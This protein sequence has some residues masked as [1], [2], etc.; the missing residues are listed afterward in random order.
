MADIFTEV[1][2]AMKQERLEK[3]WQ[4]YGGFFLGFLGIVV[5]GTAANAG[6]KSWNISRN[7]AQ[8]TLFLNTIENPAHTPQDLLNLSPDLRSGLRSI[9]EI[10]AAGLAYTNGNNDKALEIYQNLANNPAADPAIRQLASYMTINLSQNLGTEEKRTK[11]NAMIR[12]SQNPWRYHALMDAA[13]LEAVEA[14]DYKTARTHL[15]EI[16]KSDMAPKTLKQKAQSLDILYAL[17]EKI[18][19]I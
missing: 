9:T 14:Q 13:L 17:K 6:Y 1:D 12:D 19:N 15:A 7:T 8:T 11:L 2:E 3:L 16:L 5:L 18:Q 4:R 10:Q